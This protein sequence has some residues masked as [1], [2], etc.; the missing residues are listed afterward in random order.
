MIP[1]GDL[2]HRLETLIKQTTPSK[3]GSV[4]VCE[5]IQPPEKALVVEREKSG[6]AEIACMVPEGWVCI[7]WNL[8][9]GLF[10]FLR[11]DK[12]ADGAF[13][14]QQEKGGVIEAHIVECKRTVDQKKWTDIVQQMRWTL[15]KLLALAGA[16]GLSLSRVV[17]YTAFR[18]D[19]LSFERSPNLT[20]MKRTIGEQSEEDL[21]INEEGRE[22]LDW[23]D[24]KV[25]LRGF[26]GTF[27]HRKIQLDK[28]TGRG[29][30]TFERA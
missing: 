24:D 3:G 23:E 29:M 5:I 11:E 20:D 21:Q 13:F 9:T 10:G 28:E 2:P 6:E 12:N 14:L 4:K 16:L 22:L 8:P 30:F 25:R 7:Q 26:E 19:S 17:L 27:S 18:N 15:S 1:S